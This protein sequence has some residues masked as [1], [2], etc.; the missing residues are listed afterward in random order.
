MKCPENE[1]GVNR[2]VT[3]GSPSCWNGMESMK[4]GFSRKERSTELVSGSGPRPGNISRILCTRVHRQRRQSYT[5][6]VAKP[7]KSGVTCSVRSSQMLET[8]LQCQMVVR[9]PVD[10]WNE[11]RYAAA[12]WGSSFFRRRELNVKLA[13]A[14]A[15]G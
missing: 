4:G 1:L 12:P 7:W 14:S 2:V 13:A 6:A 5:Y 3:A 11:C 10:L 15:R 8:F 9:R